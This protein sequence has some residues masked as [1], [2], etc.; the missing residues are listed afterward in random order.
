MNWKKWLCALLSAVL[1]L[2]CL[3]ACADETSRAIEGEIIDEYQLDIDLDEVTVDELIDVDDLAA[4]GALDEKGW[5]NILLLGSDSRSLEQYSRT[6]AIIILSVNPTTK[7]VRLSSIMRDVWVPIYNAGSN[8]INVA[9]KFGGPDLVMR[10]VNENFGMNITDYAL[11]NMRAFVDIVDLLGGIELSVNDREMYF[12]NEQQY[13]NCQEMGID[14]YA[15]LKECGENVRL[16]GNQAL[17]YVRI[18][19]LD[20]DYVRTGRQRD[21]LVA[22]ARKLQNEGTIG[23]IAGVVLTLLSYVDTNLT[24]TELLQLSAIG[25]QMD[26]DS[27]QQLRVPVDGSYWSAEINGAKVIEID[28]SKNQQALYE[29]IYGEDE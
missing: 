2:G 9:C 11:V 15:E 26:M 25:L 1:T 29:F 17:A 22:I 24:M 23:T 16:D 20:N 21:A 18:R 28:F 13:W 3:P 10:T 6:D 4:N 7:E 12:I 14:S 19:H 8:R 27:V 5:W